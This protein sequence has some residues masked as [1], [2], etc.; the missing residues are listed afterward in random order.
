MYNIILVEESENPERNLVAFADV[1]LVDGIERLCLALQF[2][3]VLGNLELQLLVDEEGAEVA[4]LVHL[5]VFPERVAEEGLQHVMLVE[6][7]GVE[8]VHE[9]GVVQQHTGGFLGEFVAFPINHVDQSSLLQI[10]DV[11][12]H[13]RSRHAK[14]LGKLTHVRHRTTA[15]GQ[16]IEQLL[17][18]R[19]VLQLY[20]FYE[21]YVNLNHHIHVLEEVFRIVRVG[22]EERVETVVEVC[23][24]VF[25]RINFREDFRCNLSVV[26]DDFVECVRTQ[27]QAGGEVQELAER[28]ATQVVRLHDAVQFGILF[29]QTHHGRPSEDNLQAWVAVV[30]LTQLGAPVGLF[31]HLVDEQHLAARVVELACKL[32]DAYVLHVK[33]VSV[34]IQTRMVV[35]GEMFLCIL[36][37][38]SGFA[39]TASA[40]DANHSVFPVNFVHQ[41]TTHGSL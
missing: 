22:K 2:G 33:V 6:A 23:L 5:V 12:H 19:Q 37:K 7:A 21:K 29:L 30:T 17:N 38:E 4:V 16:K 28:E 39:H 26:V 18:L 32:G 14:F 15:G 27:L 11:M 1:A 8:T 40:L 41:V 20:T 3:A 13:C 24:E 9:V 31:V 34:D 25:A 10:L 35:G 36:Q